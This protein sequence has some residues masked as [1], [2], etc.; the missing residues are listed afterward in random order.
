MRVLTYYRV[1][2]GVSLVSLQSH[3]MP[4]RHVTGSIPPPPRRQGCWIIKWRA[5]SVTAR[6][7]K[8]CPGN[9][10]DRCARQC[11]SNR[12][13][14]FLG[15]C[16]GAHLA[17]TRE[18]VSGTSRDIYIH[19]YSQRDILDH[20]LRDCSGH[21]PLGISRIAPHSTRTARRCP[22]GCEAKNLVHLSAGGHP[23]DGGERASVT[24]G[25]DG[26]PGSGR[27]LPVQ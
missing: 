3:A 26:R 11:P 1:L 15:P 5:R 14:G 19:H 9:D 10:I 7:A 2:A 18:R 25:D 6:P 20:H 27:R 17:D 21:S 8:T 16:A 24:A 13:A 23:A 12:D 22:A 4:L